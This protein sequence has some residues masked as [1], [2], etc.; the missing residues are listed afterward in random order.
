LFD[1]YLQPE[2]GYR[3]SQDS[4]LL[5][6][7]CPVRQTGRAAD[8]GAGCGVVSLEALA[9]GRLEGLEELWLVEADQQFKKTL[10]ANVERHIA[11]V[12]G[13]EAPVLKARGIHSSGL[14]GGGSCQEH[15]DSKFDG[16]NPLESASSLRLD[17]GLISADCLMPDDSMAGSGPGQAFLDSQAASSLLPSRPS[18]QKPPLGRRQPK[19]RILWADWRNLSPENFGG[20]LDLIVSNPP[21]FPP[22]ASGL[23][24]PGRESSRHWVRG[25]L[26]EFLA[27]SAALLRP[28]GRLLMS[29]PRDRLRELV[30]ALV[31]GPLVFGRINVPSQTRARPTLVELVRS[32]FKII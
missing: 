7:W 11:G 22:G 17:G 20:W 21:Y 3:F 26:N 8:L 6:R 13:L 31:S 5:A 24:K 16:L 12:C 28:G 18:A 29:W 25:G 1:D 23:S 15:S 19:F 14:K 30:L 2:R 9:F 10:V 4:I 27:A 32:C